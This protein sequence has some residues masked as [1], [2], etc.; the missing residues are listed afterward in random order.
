MK[1]MIWMSVICLA[2]FV[3]MIVCIA[4][5]RGLSRQYEGDREYAVVLVNQDEYQNVKDEEHVKGAYLV[6]DGMTIRGEATSRETTVSLVTVECDTNGMFG[7]FAG[8]ADG[9]ESGCLLSSTAA[10]EIFG[11]ENAAGCTIFCGGVGYTVRSVVQSDEP[12]LLVERADVPTGDRAA[13]YTRAVTGVILDVSDEL[14]RG[15]YADVFCSA[16]GLDSDD[17]Y[18][19]SDYL[20]LLPS[21]E[22]P[23]KWSDFEYWGEY[24]DKL[25]ARRDRRLYAEKDAVE[26]LYVRVYEELCLY[27]TW[28]VVCAVIFAAAGVGLLMAVRRRQA[29]IPQGREVAG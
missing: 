9:D 25:S 12:I 15:Q 24:A 22:F 1:K 23:A 13:T 16:H 26:L 28:T 8:L 14:Y 2:G 17:S 20:D 4:L 6:R 19:I 27:R 5:L 10:N 29:R 18:Y 21:P 7:T 3:G 11:T